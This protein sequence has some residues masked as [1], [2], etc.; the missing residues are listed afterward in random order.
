MNIDLEKYG[1]KAVK[2]NE[3]I[4]GDEFNVLEDF[5]PVRMNPPEYYQRKLVGKDVIYADGTPMALPEVAA[6]YLKVDE[7]VFVKV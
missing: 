3:L 5:D 7:T 1:L 2:F 6:N 4:D